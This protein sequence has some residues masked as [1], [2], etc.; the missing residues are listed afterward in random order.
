MEIAGALEQREVLYSVSTSLAQKCGAR[1]DQIV[2]QSARGRNSGKKAT[3]V[4]CSQRPSVKGSS[5]E[6]DRQPNAR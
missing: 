3:T 4:L 1:L 2:C 6:E 5:A